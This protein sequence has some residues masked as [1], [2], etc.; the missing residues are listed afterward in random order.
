MADVTLCKA[1]AARTC[2]SSYPTW[3]VFGGARAADRNRQSGGTLG[4][5]WRRENDSD[6]RVSQATAA[7]RT[8][9][10]AAQTLAPVGGATLADGVSVG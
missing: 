1:V 10:P 5:K 4:V 8:A 3:Q 2:A 6:D 7:A 9:G